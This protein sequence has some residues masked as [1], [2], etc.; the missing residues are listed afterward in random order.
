MGPDLLRMEIR[1][2]EALNFDIGKIG[3]DTGALAK[4][5]DVGEPVEREERQRDSLGEAVIQFNIVFDDAGQQDAWFK[6]VRNLK[7]MYS[8]NDTL[9]ER[10]KLY[11]VESF[12]DA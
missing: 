8:N 1:E 11:V 6:L 7:Q 3:F 12:P 9:G 10:I 2:L 5:F 4:L